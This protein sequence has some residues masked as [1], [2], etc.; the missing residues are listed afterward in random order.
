MLPE[1]ARGATLDAR[2]DLFSLA[3]TLY[4]MAMGRLPHQCGYHR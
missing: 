2:T 3:A 4:E 1:E